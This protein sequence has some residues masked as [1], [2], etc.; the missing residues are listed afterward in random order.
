MTANPVLNRVVHVFSTRFFLC[1]EGIIF[2]QGLPR[3]STRG[4]EIMGSCVP[5]GV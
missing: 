4:E 1:A 3:K 5:M 2:V